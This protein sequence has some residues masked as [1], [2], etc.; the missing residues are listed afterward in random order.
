MRQLM[1]DLFRALPAEQI[2]GKR[3][4]VQ[5]AHT[6]LHRVGVAVDIAALGGGVEPRPESS[7]VIEIGSRERKAPAKQKTHHHSGGKPFH[8]GES[9]SMAGM[10]TSSAVFGAHAGRPNTPSEGP[11]HLRINASV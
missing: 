4:I 5:L 11:A 7:V 9:P 6:D 8:L 2:C 1:D 10:L 3:K